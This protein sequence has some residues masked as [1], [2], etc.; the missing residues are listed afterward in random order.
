MG[1]DYWRKRKFFALFLFLF[2]C[3]AYFFPRWADPNQN[4][5]LDMV[6][7]VVEDG[8]FQIDDYVENTVDYAK[9]GDHYY[10]D[11]APGAAFLGIPLYAGLKILLDSPLLVRLT[12]RIGQSEAFRT[13]LPRRR[14]RCLC[15][16]GT[17][18][19]CPSCPG[20]CRER[21]AN[22]FAWCVAFL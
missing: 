14:L 20:T 5:R 4:S 16:E 22:C 18:C 2:V 8:T 9:V 7:A 3:N 10:S 13:T 6:V 1:L 17:L 11:K 21:A 12:D 19:A 15:R